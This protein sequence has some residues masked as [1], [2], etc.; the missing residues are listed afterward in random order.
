MKQI[1]LSYESGYTFSADVLKYFNYNFNIYLIY[2]LHE[3]D[4][5][6]YIKLYMVKIL[7]EFNEKVSQTIRRM[8]EWDKMKYIIKK[9]I[10][11]IRNNNI[12]SFTLLDETELNGLIIY[13]SRNFKL[14]SDLVEILSRNIENQIL[15]DETLNENDIEELEILDLDDHTNNDEKVEPSSFSDDVEVLEL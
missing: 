2:T 9:L 15:I 6:G 12:K 13:E 10:D 11:E 5:K 14:S 8:S 1:L 7:E 3:Q 4:E